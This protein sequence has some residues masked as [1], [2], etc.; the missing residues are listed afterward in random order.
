MK[1]YIKDQHNSLMIQQLT[2]NIH[3]SVERNKHFVKLYLEN[4]AND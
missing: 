2:D 4:K 3:K 1:K